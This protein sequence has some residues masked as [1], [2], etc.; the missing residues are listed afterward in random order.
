[1]TVVIL[2]RESFPLLGSVLSAAVTVAVVLWAPAV[3]PRPTKLVFQVPSGARVALVQVR[4]LGLAP[5]LNAHP[6]GVM[7][8]PVLKSILDGR[9]T[10]RV[11][12][13]VA[14]PA[15]LLVDVILKVEAPPRTTGSGLQV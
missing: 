10:A 3:R 13:E 8:A 5:R 11:R 7:V 4:V 14:V 9:S 2:V 15:S 1:M 12:V 6:A